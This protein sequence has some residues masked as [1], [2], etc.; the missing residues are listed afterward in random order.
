MGGELPQIPMKRNYQKELDAFVASLESRPTLLLHSCCGPCSSAVLERLSA[1]FRISVFYY[2][3]NVFPEAEYLKRKREQLRLLGMV[4]GDS[5]IP[6]VDADYEPAL[7][8]EAARG[9]GHLPEGGARCERC[10]A[11]RLEKT[12]EATN[13][14]GFDLFGTTL[15][16]SPH[17]NADAVN[18]IGERAAAAHGVQ[19][20]P[21]DFKKKD[22]Y[23]RSVELSRQYGLYRQHYCGCAFSLNKAAEGPEP[24]DQVW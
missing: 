21:A 16:V 8:E 18:T 1:S 19:W 15:T 12:A 6:V 23:R 11:L 9:L 17:K 7:F 20:L 5:P 13:R 3:P 22:G 10:F 14:L 24:T 2:N 4:G